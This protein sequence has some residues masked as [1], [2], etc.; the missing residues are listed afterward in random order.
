MVTVKEPGIITM[1]VPLFPWGGAVRVGEGR[2]G[3]EMENAIP[4]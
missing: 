4:I 2:V 1:I 3:A